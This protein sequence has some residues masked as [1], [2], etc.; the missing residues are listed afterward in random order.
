MEVLS[1]YIAD[2]TSSDVSMEGRPIRHVAR[3]ELIRLM[4]MSP[5]GAL[6]RA[7]LDEIDT[8]SGVDEYRARMGAAIIIAGLD[9]PVAMDRRSSAMALLEAWREETSDQ[10]LREALARALRNLDPQWRASGTPSNPAGRSEEPDPTA[11]EAGQASP[12]PSVPA[13]TAA[14]RGQAALETGEYETAYSE[15]S[16]S[17]EAGIPA[18]CH[19]LGALYRNGLG[20]DEDLVQAAHFF[21]TA[22][23]GGEADA[24]YNLAALYDE[25][26]G[27]TKDRG[28]AAELYNLA[29]HGGNELAC[30]LLVDRPK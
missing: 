20:V 3:E 15:F 27:V 16:T 13:P 6:N 11:G 21:Q 10:S 12:Q 7:F 19:A 8:V 30:L 18:S 23:D 1:P 25:G 14:E 4:N 24:C 29:C 22:C 5:N 2:L 9:T 17:C 26:Q 28:R